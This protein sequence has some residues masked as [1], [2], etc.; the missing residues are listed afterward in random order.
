[1]CS[2][3]LCRLTCQLPERMLL[4]LPRSRI[5]SRLPCRGTAECT[6]T[7]AGNSGQQDPDAAVFVASGI[8]ACSS[9]LSHMCMLFVPLILPGAQQCAAS[10]VV[11]SLRMSLMMLSAILVPAQVC[12]WLLVQTT[13]P[14]SSQELGDM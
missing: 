12:S 5:C 2:S 9:K 8:K 13:L 7:A 4:G 6:E 10:C 11:C 3:S 1:M 14:K